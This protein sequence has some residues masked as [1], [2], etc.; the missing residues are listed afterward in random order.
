MISQSPCNSET[1]NFMLSHCPKGIPHKTSHPHLKDWYNSP[2]MA[3]ASRA[4]HPLALAAAC[5]SW[6]PENRESTVGFLE[7]ENEGCPFQGNRSWKWSHLGVVLKTPGGL[8]EN[9]FL[10]SPQGVPMWQV[11]VRPR[12]LCFHKH[13]GQLCCSGPQTILRNM[14][15]NE[16]WNP[17]VSGEKWPTSMAAPY[18][19]GPLVK[20]PARGLAHG[21]KNSTVKWERLWN[22]ERHGFYVEWAVA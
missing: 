19:R 16:Q 3:A 10:S 22:R 11:W 6:R 1:Q 18:L 13:Y 21:A 2:S 14:A 20:Q 17:Q 9:R 12:G 15:P 5:L 7:L 4:R 8:V